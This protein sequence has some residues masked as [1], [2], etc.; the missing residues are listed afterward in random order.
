VLELARDG[1]DL[2]GV[3]SFHGGLETQMPAVAGEVKARIL[4]CNGA[5]DPM[6]P[7]K[8]VEA[9]EDEMKKAGADFQVVNYPDA[10]HGFTKPKAD[11]S[12]APGILYNKSADE[13]SWAAMRAF[14]GEVFRN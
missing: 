13:R 2:A 4:V 7:P 9:F 1:A 10:V 3:V 11:G 5:D 12:I 6:V 8:Q 14:F